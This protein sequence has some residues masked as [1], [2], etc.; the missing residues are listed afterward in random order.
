VKRVA[1]AH[2]TGP[3]AFQAFRELYGDRSLYAGLGA[4]ILFSP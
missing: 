3:L 4:E 1:P 2:C